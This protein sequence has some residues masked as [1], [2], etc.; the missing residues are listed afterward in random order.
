MIGLVII[1]YEMQATLE[2]GRIISLL[3]IFI[4]NPTNLI[5]ELLIIDARSQ[6]FL[7]LVL[8]L[9]INEVW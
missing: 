5:L 4:T 9:V 8:C 7:D 1:L 3:V 6:Y 2:T